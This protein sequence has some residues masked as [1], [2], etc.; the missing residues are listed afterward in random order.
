MELS[1]KSIEALLDLV[2]IKLSCIEISDREDAREV[3]ILQRA[4]QE[5]RGTAGT[6]LQAV[7]TP[8]PVARPRFQRARPI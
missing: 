7:A 1:R 8:S 2:E 3:K 5:L 4:K 6:A